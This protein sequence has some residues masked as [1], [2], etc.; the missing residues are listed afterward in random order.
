MHENEA[1]RDLWLEDMRQQASYWIQMK[2][3]DKEISGWKKS[4]RDD[5]NEL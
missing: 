2:I 1:Q 3:T 4:D 5:H